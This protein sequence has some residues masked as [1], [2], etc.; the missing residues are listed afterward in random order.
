MAE[1]EKIMNIAVGDIEKIMNIATGDIEKV[2]GVELPA[3]SPAWLGARALLIGRS[4]SQNTVYTDEVIYRTIGA[5][6]G[7]TT[8]FGNCWTNR[9]SGAANSS[10][11]RAV[12]N[13]GFIT[14]SPYYS[15]R[16]DY[17]TIASTGDASDF[18]DTS[19][20]NGSPAA[21][22]NGTTGTVNVGGYVGAYVNQIESITFASL[23]DST[24][25]A[26]LSAARSRPTGVS[27]SVRGIHAGGNTLAF[28]DVI[29]YYTWADLSTNAS[30][31]GNLTVA[32]T[33]YTA[34]EDATRGIWFGL[35]TGGTTTPRTT[36]AIDY[37]TIASAGNASDFGDTIA[38]NAESSPAGTWGGGTMSNGVIMEVAGGRFNQSG[39]D[40]QSKAIQVITIQTTGDAVDLSQDVDSWTGGDEETYA[41][42]GCSGN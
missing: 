6:S 29:D 22:S 21:S 34:G 28:S 15:P 35:H 26:N 37:V 24:D 41:T 30:D 16:M 10:G 13:G 2:M 42:D 12:Y 7:G 25:Q 17:F 5:G 38:M 20:N 9:T 31:F 8:D 32:S 40:E 3:S 4:H 27:N 14:A 39:S 11:T 23:S 33:T 36:R 1:A 19:N 18:G